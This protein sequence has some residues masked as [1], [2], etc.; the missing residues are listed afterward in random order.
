MVELLIQRRLSMAT[1]ESLTGGGLAAEFAGVPGV[2]AVF[3]GGVVAYQNAI[4]AVV[5]GVPTEL[6]ATV[7]SVDGEVARQMALGSCRVM[8]SRVG[9]AT[10]GA[11]GPEPHD[12]KA[13]GTVFVAVA[14]DGEASFRECH[15][16]GSRAEIRT[17]AVHA[18]LDL[19]AE[20][21]GAS[22]QT[23]G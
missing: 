2:S 20:V 7:G 16:A 21:L 14:L 3:Q 13:V 17:Q 11:A 23:L 9:I 4:K 22:Q 8:K 10:T 12:G 1:A 6:L 5:L 18:A 19:L 15:F